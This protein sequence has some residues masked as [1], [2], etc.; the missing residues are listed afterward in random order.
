MY[1]RHDSAMTRR[2]IPVGMVTVRYLQVARTRRR[3]VPRL[4]PR[5]SI[6]LEHGNEFTCLAVTLEPPI[7]IEP[8]TYALREARFPAL[9][10]RPAL[11]HR[12]RRSRCPECPEFHPLPFHDLFHAEGQQWSRYVTP[13]RSGC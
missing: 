8:M 7:G 3:L 12:R 6:M 9:G 11:M 10:A 2:P 1:P 5:K 4:V 13:H